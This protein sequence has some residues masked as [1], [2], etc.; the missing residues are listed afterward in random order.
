MPLLNNDAQLKKKKRWTTNREKKNHRSFI[1]K[2][3]EK[4]NN[5]QKKKRVKKKSRLETQ[6][7]GRRAKHPTVLTK[8]KI[9]ERERKE[10]IDTWEREVALSYDYNY[11]SPLAPLFSP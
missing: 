10:T 7:R 3:K 6:E 4:K 5:D 9:Q 11:I 8:P 1:K 2:E